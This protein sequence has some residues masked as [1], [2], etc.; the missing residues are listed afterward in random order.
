MQ[1]YKTLC[2]SVVVLF[3]LYVSYI[4]NLRVELY[5]YSWEG[6]NSALSPVVHGNI[7]LS[8]IYKQSNHSIAITHNTGIPSWK[9]HDQP[10]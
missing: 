10:Q 5:L 9:M 4:S 7:T 6:S 1:N 2:G 3:K 8:K